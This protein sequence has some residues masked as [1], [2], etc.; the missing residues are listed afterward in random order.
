MH[1]AKFHNGAQG[2]RHNALAPMRACK[3][4]A[5]DAAFIPL[6][7]GIVTTGPDKPAI[8]LSPCHPVT[9]HGINNTFPFVFRP[10]R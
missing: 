10:S 8:R 9:P 2:F 5:G 6:F 1:K 7:K 3:I 4:I